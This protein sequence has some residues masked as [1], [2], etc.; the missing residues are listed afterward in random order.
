[1]I[2]LT[3][4]LLTA[5]L[6]LSCGK[7]TYQITAPHPTLELSLLQDSYVVDQP[8]YLQLRALQTG[9]EGSFKLSALLNE[10]ACEVAMNT[11]SVPTTGEWV[12]LP[13]PTEI[14]TLT[15]RQTGM[16][17]MSF[18]LRNG[19][20]QTSDRS[21]INLKVAAS[22]A[23]RFEVDYPQ[24][25]SITKPV[26]IAVT[27]TKAGLAGA[28]PVKFEQLSNS[29]TMQYG[30]VAVASG[31]QVSVPINSTQTF[32]YTPTA[33]GIHKLQLSATDGYSTEFRPLEI[34]IT[35]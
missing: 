6:M 2:R 28:L 19:E 29:G 34:I 21:V 11:Q 20:S 15:P 16:L 14:L 4:T 33:R 31:D 27:L 5:T 24:T 35:N 32:Y 23:L 13:S 22:T 8:V 30:S 7:P 12:S 17:R 10:G 18:E 26:Q 3:L 25:A 9:Y 1:M